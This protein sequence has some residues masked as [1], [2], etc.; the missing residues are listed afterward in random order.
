MPVSFSK[1]SGPYDLDDRQLTKASTLIT[2]GNALKEDTGLAPATSGTEVF[3]IAL[4]TKAAAVAAQTPI[5]IMWAYPNRTRFYGARGSG[6]LAAADVNT[7]VDFSSAAAL[8]CDVTT[9]KDFLLMVRLSA[10]EAV[11]IFSNTVTVNV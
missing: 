2:A 4:A 10:D 7:R 1:F 3:G 11:G 8:A 6:T 5:L 9:N